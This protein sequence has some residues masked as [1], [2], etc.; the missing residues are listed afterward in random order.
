M[1]T[2]NE[3]RILQTISFFIVLAAVG[4]ILYTMTAPYIM[5]LFWAGVVAALFH[6]LYTRILHVTKRQAVSSLLT[7]LIIFIGV[8]LPTAGIITLV[9]RQSISTYEYVTNPAT[10]EVAQTEIDTILHQP[11]VEKYGSQINVKER[12]ASIVNSVAKNSLSIARQG[13]M[14]AVQGIVTFAIMLYCL[15]FFLKDGEEWL[16]RFMELL[17]FGDDNER[18]LYKKFVSTARATLKGTFLIGVI[19]G[20]LGGIF[21]F[22]CGVPSS[23]FWGLIMILLCIIPAVGPALVLVPVAIF[24]AINALWWKVG[25]IVL[26]MVIIGLID[27]VLRGPLVGKDLQM[28]PVMILFA[29][30]GGIGMFGISGVVIGPMIAAFFFALIQMYEV[31]YK[32]DLRH[33]G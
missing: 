13:S 26:G 9:V 20:S 31:K 14:S 7:M 5:S 15:F 33:E 12:T 25:V 32:N 10:I 11:L 17:P 30:I 27:N 24:F 19:Q 2:R 3:F 16:K 29:T 28:H 22:I 23:A 4:W 6:P 1:N 8:L 18:I 21:L